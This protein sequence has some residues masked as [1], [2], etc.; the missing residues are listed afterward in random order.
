MF[1]G[2]T[3]LE[4]SEGLGYVMDIRRNV[5]VLECKRYF[6]IIIALI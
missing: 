1:V 3:T 4:S 5:I 2:K 6:K